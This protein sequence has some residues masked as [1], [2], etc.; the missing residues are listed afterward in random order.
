MFGFILWTL[1]GV[2]LLYA[3]LS[4]EKGRKMKLLKL[5]YGGGT[6]VRPLFHFWRWNIAWKIE[7]DRN[8][9]SIYKGF[10]V[11]RKK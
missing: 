3:V 2:L 8:Q 4:R 1:I 6:K 10:I 5:E 11:T 9:K 7:W